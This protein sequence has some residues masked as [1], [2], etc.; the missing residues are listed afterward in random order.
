MDNLSTRLLYNLDC[1]NLLL[2]IP[3]FFS[4]SSFLLS[5]YRIFYAFVGWPEGSR[6]FGE[7]GNIVISR[8]IVSR[9]LSFAAVS[10]PPLH[11][12]VRRTRETSV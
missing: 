3:F 10:A 4:S 12:S 2:S 6:D 9:T 7:R 11:V 8:S 5:R 1:N